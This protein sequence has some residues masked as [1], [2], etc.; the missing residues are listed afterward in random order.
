MINTLRLFGRLFTFPVVD[1]IKSFYKQCCFSIYS[2]A[3]KSVEFL[4]ARLK[5]DLEDKM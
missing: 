3:H 4:E 1:C 5:N 2:L